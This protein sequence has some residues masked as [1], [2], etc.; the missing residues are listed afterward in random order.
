MDF[1]K[2]LSDAEESRQEK[3]E[4]RKKRKEMQEE[5]GPEA[6]NMSDEAL[7]SGVE[8]KRSRARVEAIKALASGK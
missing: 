3:D 7:E 2:W 6:K 5:L 8:K 4:K 1:D